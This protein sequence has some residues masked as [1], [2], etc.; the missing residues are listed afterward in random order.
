MLA[1]SP[2]PPDLPIPPRLNEILETDHRVST[3][4]KR[5]MSRYLEWL[6]QSTMPFFPGYTDHGPDHISAVLQT[7]DQII[8]TESF[9][10]LTATDIAML[11]LA[12]L[13][14]DVA[15]HLTKDGFLRLVK[16]ETKLSPKPEFSDGKW[17][18]LWERFVAETFR[19]SGT[20]NI[21]LYGSPEPVPAPPLDSSDWGEKQFLLVGEFI[22]RHHPA[23][24]H[25]IALSGFPGAAHEELD[26]RSEFEVDL[27][28]IAGAIARSHGMP[29]R[30]CV[31]YVGRR[32]DNRV[33]PYGIH[34]VFLMVVLRISDYLQID[35]SR[36]QTFRLRMQSLK[37]PVS[38]LEHGKHGAVPF[39]SRD[40]KD[41]EALRLFVSAGALTHVK[42]FLSI[43]GLVRDI[44]LEID[45]S[46]AVLGEVYGRQRD[47]NLHSLGLNVRRIHTNLHN[48]QFDRELAF[49]PLALRFNSADARL[50]RLLITPLY[51]NNPDVAVREL[52]QNAVDAVRERQGY[53]RRHGQ[54]APRPQDGDDTDVRVFIAPD[55]GGRPCLVITD[56]GIGM[57]PEIIR[58][59]FL[60]IGSS[61]RE[62]AQYK[63][64]FTERDGG[65]TVLRTGYFGIGVLT[66][67]L[68]GDE[69]Q[70]STRHIT[71]P[72][73]YQFKAGIDTDPIN[74]ERIDRSIGTTITVPLRPELVARGW[75]PGARYFLKNPRVKIN[76]RQ[77]EITLPDV[78]D[79]LPPAWQR[80][81][82]VE[83]PVVFWNRGRG[84]DRFTHNGF[85]I[86]HGDQEPLP[87]WSD[88]YYGLR[89]SC[90]HLH[91]LDRN[92]FT[93]SEYLDLSRTKFFL[94][95]FE[96]R[97]AL[98]IDLLRDYV[99]SL[100][101]L[102]PPRRAV[103]N[104]K[105]PVD[106]YLD[107][108]LTNLNGS[109]SEGIHA[110]PWVFVHDGLTLLD[111]GILQELGIKTLFVL[112]DTLVSGSIF[113]LGKTVGV[114]FAASWAQ[115]GGHGVEDLAEPRTGV[116]VA[117]GFL[118][119]VG[120]CL[121]TFEGVL[122]SRSR[123]VPYRHT[124]SH[125]S[126]NIPARGSAEI[127]AILHSTPLP[128]ENQQVH[129]T[130]WSLDQP[131]DP[132]EA[133]IPELLLRRAKHSEA[134]ATEP[135]P[136][137]AAWRA[138]V[139]GLVIP[140]AMK[141]RRAILD[142]A[143]RELAPYIEAW[144]FL[145]KDRG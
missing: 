129:I 53:E 10:L 93:I 125:T 88:D 66:A 60:R 118:R 35:K 101:V 71:S 28:D 75:T 39:V 128:G 143:Y 24:A 16:G 64:E 62:S 138:F 50:F 55:G 89:I 58:D 63:A 34:A 99:A 13:L 65:S 144:E 130:E 8:G 82:G 59:Y 6:R 95:R 134:S 61:F 112:G 104:W 4:A 133:S 37:S 80:L 98:F 32:Y 26:L 68:V 105:V 77:S 102:T 106:R 33:D 113:R 14:H 25:Q 72:T 131:R 141:R 126:G 135:T 121:H 5:S 94:E 56:S 57:T 123:K 51:G 52:I 114:V 7:A 100:M 45:N 43:S 74:L 117:P 12:V 108:K 109:W 29:L 110:V 142:H 20:Q 85:M 84:S 36:S 139:P 15:L 73:G 111:A 79:P 137:V 78:D 3:S 136:L 17:S 48:P 54:L 27:L 91:V 22:R 9:E 70:V 69:V 96:P 40:E 97:N 145:K 107:A 140:Y 90:P 19:F 103:K 132:D 2:I 31:D 42:L 18:V 87:L 41:P 46:W 127:D 116:N 83:S 119:I 76:D 49:E 21:N 1:S 81:P 120:S 38:A 44:Q 11:I 122:A 67:F 47:R 92:G 23:L 86:E 124:R 30:P 115:R